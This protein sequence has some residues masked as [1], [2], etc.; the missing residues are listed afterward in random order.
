MKIPPI[1][2][3]NYSKQVRGAALF[4]V[5]AII[6]TFLSVPIMI[7]YLGVER[8]GVWSTMLTMI[9]WVMMFDLGVGNGLKN[10]ISESLA[11]NKPNK[12]TEFIST[13]Y[14]FIG[15]ISAL[16][17][18]ILLFSVAFVPWQKVFNT[19]EITEDSLRTA[20]LLLGSFIFFNFW[21]S[22][23]S[24][25]YHGLQKSSYVIFGQFVSNLLA[26]LFV[27][28]LYYTSEASMVRIVAAYGLA[29]IGSNIFLST[30]IFRSKKE[31]RPKL[32][33]FKKSLVRPLLTL[34]LKF[35]V[36]Q[37]AVII[38]F[39]TDKIIITQL[40][41]PAH[42]TSYEVVFKIFSVFT[43]LHS[44]ILVPVWPA[45]SNAYAQGDFQWI[46]TTLK[47]QILI[48]LLLFFGAIILS[49]IGPQIVRL[50][51]GVDLEI[52]RSLYYMLVGFI[53]V[54]VWSNVFAYF[55]NAVNKINIQLYAS[56]IAAIINIPMSIYF[57]S[58]LGM[59]LTGIVLATTLSL[60]I[61]AIAGPIQ[62]YRI[63]KQ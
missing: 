8:F 7:K 4:K 58:H 25:I 55:V 59:G 51:I 48:A 21:I 60:S 9:T 5:G 13:A 10:K 37:I 57:V 50:W 47:H 12:A 26:L 31:F 38:I 36:I 61:F 45:Y 22:L 6:C 35:F 16:F 39:M 63:L 29:L 18:C 33:Y 20:V 42:V 49:W 17:F 19:N 28:I 46:R 44:L 34:G 56:I 41:G 54:S 3:K 14:V 40:L 27:L 52:N 43:I 11:I 30:L 1:R 32:S 15:L 62:V 53:I 2:S 24:Q 23:V